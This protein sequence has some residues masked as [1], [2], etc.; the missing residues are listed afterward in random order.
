MRRTARGRRPCSDQKDTLLV[1]HVEGVLAGV[2]GLGAA[3]AQANPHPHS[4]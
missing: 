3:R 2:E 1:K 4:L